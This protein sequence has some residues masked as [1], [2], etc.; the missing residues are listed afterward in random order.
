M[1]TQKWDLL[2]EALLWPEA[3]LAF[4]DDPELRITVGV[5]ALGLQEKADRSDVTEFFLL[6]S[7]LANHV[8]SLGIQRFQSGHI[9]LEKDRIKKAA[10]GRSAAEQDMA[11]ACANVPPADVIDIFLD[12]EK[13]LDNQKQKNLRLLFLIRA[14]RKEQVATMGSVDYRAT[15]KGN[16]S[17]LTVIQ[18]VQVDFWLRKILWRNFACLPLV[19]H[20]VI[21]C[22]GARN[23][24]WRS[25]SGC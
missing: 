17:W 23:R 12:I 20:G 9:R 1:T 6:D 8:R 3:L 14:A 10:A 7:L 16:T 13:M 11:L 25:L 19:N 21:L 15:G 22:L 2:T 18:V 4:P 24:T 5:L